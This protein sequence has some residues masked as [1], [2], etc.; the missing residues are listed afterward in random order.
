V[1]SLKLVRQTALGLPLNPHSLAKGTPPC[2]WLT[3]PHQNK[4]V[5]N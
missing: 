1:Y 2:K 4:K 5:W 3:T